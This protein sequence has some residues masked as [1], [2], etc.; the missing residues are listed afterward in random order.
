M[1][2]LRVGRVVLM[3]K[4]WL[5]VRVIVSFGPNTSIVET[6]NY[7][8]ITYPTKLAVCTCKSYI[9]LVFVTDSMILP[10]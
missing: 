3:L 7:R 4:G 2:L 9:K 10:V 8:L 1:P 6:I 5:I